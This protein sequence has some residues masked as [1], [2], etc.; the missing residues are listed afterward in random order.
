MAQDTKWCIGWSSVISKVVRV[1]DGAPSISRYAATD[2]RDRVIEVGEHDS[3]R[4]SAVG[5]TV[6]ALHAIVHPRPD[7]HGPL[8]HVLNRHDHGSGRGTWAFRHGLSRGMVGRRARRTGRTVLQ[9]PDEEHFLVMHFAPPT[10]VPL[11]LRVLGRLVRPLGQLL[12]LAG[13]RY[14]VH[15]AR[16]VRVGQ[17][18]IVFT[19]TLG[20]RAVTALGTRVR[21]CG[22]CRAEKE[23]SFGLYG[24]SWM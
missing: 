8:P 7:S 3:E 19:D 11:V 16:F 1:S 10:E 12:E 18:V 2:G 20:V 6:A 22:S 21:S 14:P 4:I 15:C 5:R 13:R 17:H 9:Q 23:L 24:R